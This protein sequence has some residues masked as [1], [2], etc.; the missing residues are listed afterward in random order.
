MDDARSDQADSQPEWE[1][2]VV[3]NLFGENIMRH[4]TNPR[5]A[6]VLADPS[7]RHHIRGKVRITAD[8]IRFM[9]KMYN[10]DT[11]PGYPCWELIKTAQSIVDA[12]IDGEVIQTD[13]A[14][15]RVTVR[16]GPLVLQMRSNWVEKIS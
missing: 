14:H 11:T 6:Y 1:G 4:D 8:H 15:F 12:G 13:A 9:K 16:F 10:S 5:K 2:Q 7:S 3:I